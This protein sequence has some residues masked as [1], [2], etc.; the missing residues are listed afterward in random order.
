MPALFT[1]RLVQNAATAHD[2]AHATQ[3]AIIVN[4]G[5]IVI[6]PQFRRS[7]LPCS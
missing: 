7:Y 4:A 2:I 1:L 5:V 3:S 6:P